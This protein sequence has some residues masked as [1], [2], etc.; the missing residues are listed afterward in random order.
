MWIVPRCCGTGSGAGN[1]GKIGEL[2][3]EQVDLAARAGVVDVPDG[4]HEGLG[5]SARFHELEERDVR[6]HP[7]RH[8]GR[9]DLGA[10]LQGHTPHR[11]VLHQDPDHLG[12]GLDLRT[13]LPR[14]AGD[15]IADASHA[16]AHVAPHAADPVAL[17]H[18]VMEQDV[19]RPRHRGRRH[20]ADDRVGRERHLELLR[21]EPAVENRS[22]RPGQDLDRP[23]PLGAELDERKSQL[24]ELHQVGRPERPRVRRRLDQGRLEEVRHPLQHRLVLGQRDRVLGRELGDLAMGERLVGTEQ[25][26]AAV[27]KGRERR[28]TPGQHLEP[29]S[30][31][32]EVPNDL[33]TEEAVDIG[34]SGDLAAGPD[35]LGHAGSAQHFTALEHQHFD[36]GAGG[37][38]RCHE[39]VV[40]TTDDDEIVGCGHVEALET[41]GETYL[42]HGG[43]GRA[44]LRQYGC[45]QELRRAPTSSRGSESDRGTFSPRVRS[46]VRRSLAALG[47]R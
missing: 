8:P 13:L 6:V 42:G 35:L 30:L 47:M 36:A 9:V 20:R 4:L 22:R 43:V 15:R 19:G 44:A 11:P 40:A 16:T 39:P 2:G 17:A 37:V 26:R 29:V 1:R 46:P 38:R 25:Q 5:Q 7:R 3:E 45:M 28:R 12:I 21:L 31:Q 34:R 14:G 27:G 33:G 23:L 41:G 10:I 18:H 32:L 24:R